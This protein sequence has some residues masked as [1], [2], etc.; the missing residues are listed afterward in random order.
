MKTIASFMLVSFFS[1]SIL[2][3]PIM[4]RTLTNAKAAQTQTSQGSSVWANPTLWIVGAIAALTIF[5]IWQGN[6]PT[7]QDSSS[8][9][10][11]GKQGSGQNGANDEDWVDAGAK[12]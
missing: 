4:T 1:S 11:P 6:Q 3:A 2:S 7:K 9:A 8:T 5:K 10:A 12:H